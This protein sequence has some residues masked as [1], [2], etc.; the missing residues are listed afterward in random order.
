MPCTTSWNEKCV[1]WTVGW[2]VGCNVGV[3]LGER[4][5]ECVEGREVGASVGEYEYEGAPVVSCDVGA[6][7]EEAEGWYISKD[8]M[9]YIHEVRLVERCEGAPAK[10]NVPHVRLS[11]PSLPTP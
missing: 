2:V 7:V 9:M 3:L 11:L 1:G 5:G 4:E 8:G 6:M 10:Y